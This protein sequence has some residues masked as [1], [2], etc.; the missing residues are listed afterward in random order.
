MFLTNGPQGATKVMGGTRKTSGMV[1]VMAAEEVTGEAGEDPGEVVSYAITVVNPGITSGIA[2]PVGQQAE[3][4]EESRENNAEADKA[5][6]MIKG[7][8]KKPK[9]K[10]SSGGNGST[11]N[12]RN[13]RGKK[14]NGTPSEGTNMDSSSEDESTDTLTSVSE[15][16][17]RIMHRDSSD[18]RV[19]RKH[20]RKASKRKAKG[21]AH[22]E[23]TPPKRFERGE[24]SRQRK[25]TYNEKMKHREKDGD[26]ETEPVTPL[27]G[28]HKRLVAGCF[29]KGLIEY[30]ISTHKICS[31]KK[32]DVLKKLC[33]RKGIKYTKKPE[34]VALLARYQVELA[35]DGFEVTRHT[36]NKNAGEKT[37]ASRSPRKEFTK[38]RTTMERPTVKQVPVIIRSAPVQPADD[39]E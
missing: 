25:E 4:M 33:E 12:R 26:R 16:S 17:G 22:I 39:C 10:K 13:R 1:K 8:G 20:K 15:D 38:D 36:E 3:L 28:G 7:L 23:V 11:R 34:A 27:T 31:A 2:G 5:I 37:K 6:T 14:N 30:C 32:A 24:S 19:T 9:K 18:K 21:K 29:Q 35:Y